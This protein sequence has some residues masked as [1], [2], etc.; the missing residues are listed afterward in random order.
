MGERRHPELGDRVSRNLDRA[1][2]LGSIRTV[3]RVRGV[4]PWRS[5]EDEEEETKMSI[6][7][8]IK[9]VMR[10]ESVQVAISACLRE[11]S[12]RVTPLRECGSSTPTE[13]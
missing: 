4:S 5:D 9:S 8:A 1:T 6:R 12:Q 3:R 10:G 11:G 13:V 7:K 2:T